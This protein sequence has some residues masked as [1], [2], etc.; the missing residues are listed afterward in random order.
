MQDYTV[1]F[2][3]FINKIQKQRMHVDRRPLEVR[4]FVGIVNYYCDFGLAKV[5]V[6]LC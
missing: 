6:F 5:P 1:S 4:Q 2:V 3:I